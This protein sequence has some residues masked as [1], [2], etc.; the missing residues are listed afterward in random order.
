MKVRLLAL[1]GCLLTVVALVIKFYFIP[2][3]GHFVE[4]TIRDQMM[5]DLAAFERTVLIVVSAAGTDH[6]FVRRALYSI[7]EDPEIPIE[8]RRSRFLIEQFGPRPDREPKTDVERAVFASAVPAFIKNE[9]SYQV[10]YPL[11]ATGVCMRCHIDRTGKPIQPGTVIGL[12]VKSVPLSSTQQSNVMYF[13]MDLFWENLLMVSL[14]VG[15]MLFFVFFWI[16][17]PLNLIQDRLDAIYRERAEEWQ[18]DEYVQLGEWERLVRAI[19]FLIK[20]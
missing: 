11:R 19:E 9:K 4:L 7:S 14:A 1:A 13:I 16:F 6:E 17:K 10:I 12:A 8:L 15:I 2:A 18:L 5:R 3:T 20:E